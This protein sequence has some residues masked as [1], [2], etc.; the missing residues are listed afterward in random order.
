MKKTTYLYAFIILLLSPVIAFSDPG[1]NNGVPQALNDI[2]VEIQGLRTDVAAIEAGD[3]TISGAKQAEGL[4][5]SV[6]SG[7]S[8]DLVSITGSGTF[9]AARMT[10]QGGTNDI[11]TVEL[12]IDGQ[13]IVGRTYAALDN[14]GMTQNNP[15]GVVLLKG[16]GV[17]AV[18]IGFQQPIKFENSLILR[19]NVG[20]SGIVQMIG[21]VI[22]GD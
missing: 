3:A 13:T 4:I 19:T 15:F 8:H 5:T 1:N 21:T 14:W 11:T 16:N 22:Y 9:I 2:L 6:L 17:D 12:I 10:K 20:E 7:S 18:T